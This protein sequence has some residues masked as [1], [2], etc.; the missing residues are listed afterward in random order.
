M[1]HPLSYASDILKERESF[2]LIRIERKTED[3][4]SSYTP[5]LNDITI[6]TSSFL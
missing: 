1:D 2:V 4:G 6:V 3:E 5:L